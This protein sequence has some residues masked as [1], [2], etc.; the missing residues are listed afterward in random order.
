MPSKMTTINEAE[1]FLLAYSPEKLSGETYT[2]GRMKELMR[3]LGDPQNMIPTV[4]VAG[5]SGKTST[6]YFIRS[7]LQA[8]GKRT[9][10][11]ISPHITSITERIQVDG[12]PLDH[13]QFLVYLNE[14]IETIS[15][16]HDITL[17][18]FELLTALG[19]WVFYKE[20]VDYMVIEVGLGGLMDATN[21]ITNPNKV[22]V[23][24]PIG[25]DH[26]QILGSKI[27]DIAFQKAGII[28][29]NSTVFIAPQVDAAASI[30][31]DV[32]LSTSSHSTKTAQITHYQQGIPLFQQDNFELAKSVVN[33]LVERDNLMAISQQDIAKC[34]LA[35]PPGRFEM[36]TIGNTQVILDGAHNPQKLAAF[37]RALQRMGEPPY[38]WLV[39][40]IEAPDAKIEDCLRQIHMNGSEYYFTSFTIGGDFK[41]RKS[42]NAHELANQAQDW[43]A[44]VHVAADPGQLLKKLIREQKKRTVLVTGSL[45][46]VAQLRGLVRQLAA[47]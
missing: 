38:A 11:S 2:L 28:L 26:T 3:R 33:H 42:V 41:G 5:T 13:S 20:Q 14:F 9:G 29:P 24:T 37:C 40:F 43:D 21:V 1:Q 44:N 31:D 17:T 12:R 16:W 6:S 7:L 36:Y 19:F 15:S 46:L 8:H 4:H 30:I 32:I 23:I 34:V 10:L 27:E 22:S 25:L 39:G 35:T 45:Y 47:E 18:Y